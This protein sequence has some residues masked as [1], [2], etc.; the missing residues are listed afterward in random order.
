MHMLICYGLVLLKCNEECKSV[1]NFWVYIANVELTE[2]VY[3]TVWKYF[4]SARAYEWIKND[5]YIYNVTKNSSISNSI[6]V[7]MVSTNILVTL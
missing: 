7:I 2:S 4:R 6:L 1:F 3:T 5:K